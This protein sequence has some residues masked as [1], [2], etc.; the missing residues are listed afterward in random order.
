MQGGVQAEEMD[1]AGAGA[2]ARFA[3]QTVW[4][5]FTGLAVRSRLPTDQPSGW[6]LLRGGEP[7]SLLC[8]RVRCPLSPEHGMALLKEATGI[9]GRCLSAWH[10]L[11]LPTH[12]RWKEA[13]L[14]PK[15]DTNQIPET[16][17][18]IE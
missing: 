3:Q 10:G 2:A 15:A 18:N 1:P 12:L 5:P 11:H 9:Q 16:K 8:V 13:L 4:E 17:S 7:G 14:S 6:R